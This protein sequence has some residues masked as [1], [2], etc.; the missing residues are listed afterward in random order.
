MN[1]SGIHMA[2]LVFHLHGDKADSIVLL[3]VKNPSC[4]SED[5]GWISINNVR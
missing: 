5:F 4:Q 1:F 3:G 2:Y